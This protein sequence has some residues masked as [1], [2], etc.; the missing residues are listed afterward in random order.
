MKTIAPTRSDKLAYWI[1]HR[2]NFLFRGWHGVGKGSI[3]YSMPQ[4]LGNSEV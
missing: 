4:S 3:A 2:M 1:E